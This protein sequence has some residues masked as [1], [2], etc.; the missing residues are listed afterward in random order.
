MRATKVLAVALALAAGGL[1]APRLAGASPMD[2]KVGDVR[3]AYAKKGTTLRGD[4]AITAAAVASLP[5][6]TRVSVVEVKLPWIRVQKEGGAEAGWVKAYETVEPEVLAA[7]PPPPHVTADAGSA[8][9]RDVTAAGRQLDAATERGFRASRADLAAGY[10]AVDRLEATT[11][12]MDP[13]ETIEF[14]MEGDLGR[15]GR[16]YLRPPRLP[17]EAYVPGDDEGGGGGPSIPDVGSVPGLGGLLGKVGGKHAK[18]LGTALKVAAGLGK[19]V[20]K[21]Q[22]EFTPTQ[23]YYL[24]RAVAA[25]AIAKYGVSKDEALRKYVRLVGDAVIRVADPR[26]VVPTVCGYHFEVLDT[27]EVNGVSGPGGFVLV[28]RGAVMACQDEEELAGILLHEVAHSAR[29]HAEQVLRRGK[30]FGNMIGGL[31]SIAG[32][33]SGVDDSRWG[34]GLVD[35]F[36]KASSEMARTSQE[37]AYGPQFEYDADQFS[38][39]LL[40]DTLYDHVGLRDWLRRRGTD[41]N[42]HGDA[43]HAPPEQR[44]QYLD[45]IVAQWGASLPKPAVKVE[46]A[47]RFRRAVGRTPLPAPA[48]GGGSPASGGVTPP[49][50]PPPPTPLPR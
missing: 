50:P 16:N 4:A 5:S 13:A 17:L 34:A 18:E 33:V 35:F 39:G 44:A 32:T 26:Y 47:N 29:K 45:G 1:S 12:A 46:R 42:A 19:M 25:N 8:S 30:N 7:E 14:I 27:D 36:S 38:T 43:N 48:T 11:V 10:A 22:K 15:R 23:E 6:G 9:A 37:H 2:S 21:M 31:V 24:G 28:T 40:Y 49:P 3:V 20:S 41:P